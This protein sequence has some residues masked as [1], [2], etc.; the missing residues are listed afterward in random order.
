[1]P[2]VTTIAPTTQPMPTPLNSLK[3]DFEADFCGFTQ[4]FYDYGDW[5]RVQGT[6]IYNP[7]LTGPKNDHTLGTALGK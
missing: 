7:Y 1:M 6:G 2:P 5:S 4:Y 3:C